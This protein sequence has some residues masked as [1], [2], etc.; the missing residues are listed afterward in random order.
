MLSHTHFGTAEPVLF[1]E[2]KKPQKIAG[3]MCIVLT[4]LVSRVGQNAR[5]V[6]EGVIQGVTRASFGRHAP[7]KPQPRRASERRH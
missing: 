7:L 4:A 6:F 2:I 1:F 5:G 3:E